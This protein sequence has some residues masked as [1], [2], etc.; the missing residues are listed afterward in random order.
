M[1]LKFLGV[2]L[3]HESAA[4]CC[5][6]DSCNSTARTCG[7]K[8][9]QWSSKT[10]MRSNEGLSFSASGLNNTRFYWLHQADK[11]NQSGMETVLIA[12]GGCSATRMWFSISAKRGQDVSIVK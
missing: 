2:L 7:Q 5:A 3:Q 4:L 10:L 11:R 6:L 8:L 1:A 9:T 12:A